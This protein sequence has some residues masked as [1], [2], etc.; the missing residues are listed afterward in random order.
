MNQM[1]VLPHPWVD[2][3]EEVEEQLISLHLDSKFKSYLRRTTQKALQAK[4]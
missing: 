4:T 3:A 1:P 2:K